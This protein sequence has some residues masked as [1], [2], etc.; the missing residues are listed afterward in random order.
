MQTNNEEYTY[1]YPN[2][3]EEKAVVMW[4]TYNAFIVIIFGGLIGV[5]A[6]FTFGSIVP[7]IACAIYALFTAKLTSDMP[8]IMD[9]IVMVINYVFSPRVWQYVPGES[10]DELIVSETN[11]QRV[12]Q[13]ERKKKTKSKSKKKKELTI[14]EQRKEKVRQMSKQRKKKMAEK[15][16]G[17]KRESALKLYAPLIIV[18]IAGVLALGW[19]FGRPIITEKYGN[20]NEN[21]TI[22]YLNDTDIPW[23][24]GTVD[25]L[26]YV[27]NTDGTVTC[28]PSEIDSTKLG[29]VTVTYTVTDSDGNTKD[30]TRE[31][32]VVDTDSPIIT[33]K[34]KDVTIQKGTSFDPTSNIESVVDKVDGGLTLANEATFK[35]YT[36]TSN[37]DTDTVGDYTVSISAIDSNGNETTD[38]YSVSVVE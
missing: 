25:P 26:T 16:D 29:S 24:S 12:Y 1:Q 7:G 4:W 5:F 33:L 21:I 18:G 20:H 10:T 23:Y 35:S 37:V 9:Y 11:T 36:I 3:L 8:T 27:S 34:S 15:E 30:F 28:D 2:N 6:F 17:E 31:Y 22:N 32:N 14:E 19:F 38:S 13:K